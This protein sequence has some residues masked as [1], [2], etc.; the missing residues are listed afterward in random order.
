MDKYL[1]G[2][3]WWHGSRWV[4]R[5]F[6][7]GP[8]TSLH[9]KPATMFRIVIPWYDIIAILRIFWCDV[10]HWGAFLGHLQAELERGLLLIQ[11]KSL[12]AGAM[13]QCRTSACWWGK[14][15]WWISASW[16]ETWE[17]FL[18]YGAQRENLCDISASGWIWLCWWHRVT[19]CSNA[20]Y[21]HADEIFFLNITKQHIDERHDKLFRH[22]NFRLGVGPNNIFCWMSIIWCKKSAK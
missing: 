9:L 3:V 15:F 16:W 22:T 19:G 6:I 8:L 21:Q 4:S 11:Q 14:T 13:R 12:E 17:I 1:D 10:D 20:A 7:F 5:I 2:Q 18:Q